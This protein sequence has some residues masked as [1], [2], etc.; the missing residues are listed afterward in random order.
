MIVFDLVCACGCQFEGWFVDHNECNKQQQS[1]ILTCPTCGSCRVERI[2]SPVAIRTKA[3]VDQQMGSPVKPWEDVEETPQ[4]DRADLLIELQKFV[5][6]NFEDVG[7]RLA[8]EAL[9]MKFGVTE[10]RY[11]RGIASA[12][13]EKVLQGEGVELV[14][15]PWTKKGKPH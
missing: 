2:L 8:E 5:E 12:A 15:I 6:R 1:G 3:E 13:E 4:D 14:K 9:K 10:T 7:E 11:I